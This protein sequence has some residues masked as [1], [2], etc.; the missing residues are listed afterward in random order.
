MSARGQ[1]SW[2]QF[3]STVECL[4]RSTSESPERADDA[5]AGDSSALPLHQSLRLNLERLGFAEFFGPRED[6]EWRVAPPVLAVTP[7]GS[8]YTGFIVGARS[9]A[10][11]HRIRTAIDVNN[12]RVEAGMHF[13]DSIS[14]TT[15]DFSVLSTLA[16]QARL[17]LQINA[18]AAILATL[19]PVTSSLLRQPLEVPLGNDWAVERFREGRLKWVS[20]TREEMQQRS[21]GLFRMRYLYR[22]EIVLRWSG[23]AY[24]T[25]LQEGKFISLTR[26]RVRA[27][28]YDPLSLTLSI[29]AI[30]RPPALIERALLLCTGHLPEFEARRN[31]PARLHYRGVPPTIARTAAALLRQELL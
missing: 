30:C 24:K 26:A 8:G 2:T 25:S 13:P 23:I 15:N 16:V 28:T 4:W 12:I 10:L 7:A 20:S 22:T 11:L 27:L 14:V 19:L 18:P 5:E 17:Y 29:P 6:R 1:G 21:F 3:R 9:D 31:A